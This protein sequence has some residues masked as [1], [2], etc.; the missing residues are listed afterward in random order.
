MARPKGR[1]NG[2]TNQWL[3]LLAKRHATPATFLL[4]VMEGKAAMLHDTDI[5]EDGNERPVFSKK[6]IAGIRLEAA[7]AALPYCHP[8]LN[9]INITQVQGDE[10]SNGAERLSPADR[11][12]TELYER[13][14][15]ANI[16]VLGKD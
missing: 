1:L 11:L 2:P 14:K 5:D 16:K 13:A 9:A 3:R 15:G 12:A 4:D 6:E 7:K 8:R 10:G